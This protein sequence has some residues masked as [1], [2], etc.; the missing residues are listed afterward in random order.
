[1]STVAEQ[2]AQKIADAYQQS[3]VEDA[4]TELAYEHSQDEARFAEAARKFANTV[5][6][7][8]DAE[9]DAH[10]C[11]VSPLEVPQ[12]APVHKVSEPTDNVDI[13][14]TAVAL[15]GSR[16][17]IAPSEPPARVWVDAFSIWRAAP[18]AA[19][20]ALSPIGDK[21][22]EYAH[23]APIQEA[24]QAC[25]AHLWNDYKH[26]AKCIRKSDWDALVATITSPLPESEGESK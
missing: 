15:D 18:D 14:N 11:D 22:D 9:L 13:T 21:Y 8:I 17:P 10:R 5:V 2:I 12:D 26:E 23:L 7:I 25:K 24:L 16:Y 1:M 4:F 6:P 3:A 20:C 19:L